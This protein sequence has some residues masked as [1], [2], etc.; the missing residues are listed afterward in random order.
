M[1]DPRQRVAASKSGNEPR[2][3]AIC[4]DDYGV[5]DAVNEAIVDLAIR[6]RLTATSVLVDGA[7][8]EQA[9]DVLSALPL[10]IGLHLNFTDAIGDL[11]TKQVMPLWTLI[12]RAHARLLDKSWVRAGVERQLDRFET[13]FGR[14]PDYVDGHLHIHQLPIIRDVLVETFAQRYNRG[15]LWIRDTRLPPAM[16]TQGPWVSRVKT[17]VIGHLGM[18]TL[19]EQVKRHGWASNRGFAGVY[20]FTRPHPPF[21]EMFQSWCA[22]C[23]SGA[24]IMTH[25]STRA[26]PGDPIGQARVAEYQALTSDALGD[27]LV[28]QQIRVGRLSQLLSTLP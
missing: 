11:S 10:D 25:P 9:A 4:A 18:A 24:L 2:A 22:H 3:I 27:Y 13:L 16:Y 17:W 8:L 15:P 6:G 14:G 20:D 12:L 28:A 26:L 7:S 19:A 23:D 1:T 5:D 21:F